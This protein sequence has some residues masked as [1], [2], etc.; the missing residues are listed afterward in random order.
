MPTISTRPKRPRPGRAASAVVGCLTALTLLT[1]CDA[2]TTTASGAES[3]GAARSEAD[4]SGS[5]GA[6]LFDGQVHSITIAYDE[7]AYQAMLA[8]FAETGEKEWITA[9]VTIDGEV[10]EDV[11]IKLKGNSSLQGLAATVMSS[12]GQG[13]GTVDQTTT[14]GRAGPGGEPGGEVSA[15]EPEGLPWRIRLDKYVE[16]QDFHGQADLVVRGNRTETS[17]NEAVALD[18]IGEAGLVTQEASPVRF[19]V[20]G[21]EETLRLVIENPTDTWYADAIGTEGVLY[22]AEAEGDY[23]YRGE[24][25]DAYTDAFDIEVATGEDD[26]VP[27]VE[28]LDFVNNA[29]D[30]TFAA[31][32]PERLDVDAFATYLAIQDLVANADDIDGPGN[33]SYLHYDLESGTFTV[34]AWDQNLSFGGLGGGTGGRGGGAPPGGTADGAPPGATADGAR[35]PGAAAGGPGANRGNVLAER[36]LANE[37]FAG[38]VD[39]ASARLRAALYES[40]AARE[41]LDDRAAVLLDQASDLVSAETIEAEVAHIAGYVTTVS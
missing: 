9:T 3:V 34:V 33:N 10:F 27:L 35:A 22:K 31:D 17:L 25:P 37:E 11:G 8:T 4:G 6:D 28:F 7:T 40:G 18:L 26:Y 30:A 14:A 38:L 21:G 24:D 29:D 1:A 41:I 20:N 32:L 23:S 13:D 39:A 16:G 2:G 19:S 12:S 15:D 36:F 5:V